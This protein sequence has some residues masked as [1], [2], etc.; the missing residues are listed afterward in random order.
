M[1][2]AI[3]KAT[4]W[5]IV[6]G[7]LDGPLIIAHRGDSNAA[8]ENTLEG[9]RRALVAG[10]DG[11]DRTTTGKGPIGTF[12]LAEVKQL[13][14]GSWFAPA[15]KSAR[16]PTLGEVFEELPPSFLVNVELKVRGT[17]LQSLVS[18]VVDVIRRHHRWK[19][20]LVASFNPLALAILRAIEPKIARGYVWNRRHPLPLSARWAFPLVAPQWMDPD[21]DTFTPEV[22]RRSHARGLPVLAWD[23]DAGT[24]L[25]NAAEMELDAVVTDRLD[26]WL[27]QRV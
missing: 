13:D 19:S 17:G 12:T 24:D 16:V 9:F 21:R 2:V 20:T 11:V 8:P 7:S 3:R 15:F 6:P 10:A 5:N 4:G 25:K 1:G 26:M 14:A 23:L 18:R 27:K 22:L